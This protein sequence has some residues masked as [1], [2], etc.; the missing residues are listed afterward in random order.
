MFHW[1]L[2]IESNKYINIRK[3]T[4][5]EKDQH[6]RQVYIYIT[7]RTIYDM[8]FRAVVYIICIARMTDVEYPP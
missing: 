2:T 1:N 6:F 8:Q 3:R 7:C 5:L 4:E